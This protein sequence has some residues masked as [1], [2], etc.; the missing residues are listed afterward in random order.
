MKI[1]A[2]DTLNPGVTIE[3]V[4][5][6]LKAEAAHAWELYTKGVFREMYFRK[7][8]PGAV[9]FPECADEAE[10]R[11]VLAGLPLVKANLITFEIVPLGAFT[12][13]EAL[14]ARE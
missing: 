3:R 2:M 11:S 4:A 7:D 1:L 12:P 8:R 5:P 6:L 9:I 14:F 13:L 10:A